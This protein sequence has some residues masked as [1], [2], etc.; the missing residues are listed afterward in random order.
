MNRDPYVTFVNAKGSAVTVV[1]AW[2]GSI[3]GPLFIITE[4]GNYTDWPFYIGVFLTFIV[5]VS[6][7][8]GFKA[9]KNNI[10]SDFFVYSLIPILI[11]IVSIT[12]FVLS[13]DV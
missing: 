12:L 2:I 7:I 3:V 4:F 13:S 10:Y 6:I 9:L 11:P 8:H 1:A 5:I